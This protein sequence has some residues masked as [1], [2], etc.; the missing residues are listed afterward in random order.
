MQ[1]IIGAQ[2]K[3]FHSHKNMAKQSLI[4]MRHMSSHK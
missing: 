1:I 4:R 2:K 3:S